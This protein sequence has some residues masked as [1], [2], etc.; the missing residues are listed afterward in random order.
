MTLSIEQIFIIVGILLLSS[1]FASKISNKFGI[2]ALL[3]FLL[4]GILAGSEDSSN[5]ESLRIE[6]ELWSNHLNLG[7]YVLPKFRFVCLLG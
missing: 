5:P 4:I 6:Y 2:P 3:L 1:V 7:H